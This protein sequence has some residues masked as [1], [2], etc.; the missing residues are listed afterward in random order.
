MLSR[1]HKAG[2]SALKSRILKEMANPAKMQPQMPE[3]R[4]RP[5]LLRAAQPQRTVAVS[6]KVGGQRTQRRPNASQCR[7]AELPIEFDGG[8]PRQSS[9]LKQ[10]VEAI[11]ALALQ[12]GSELGVRPVSRCEPFSVFLA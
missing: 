10:L 8:A 2:L 4:P 12:D 9:L 11:D 7:A 3:R 1:A 6:L 5:P